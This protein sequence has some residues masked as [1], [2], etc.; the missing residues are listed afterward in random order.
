MVRSADTPYEAMSSRRGPTRSVRIL[1]S[2]LGAVLLVPPVASGGQAYQAAMQSLAFLQ[3]TA[4]PGGVHLRSL[5]EALARKDPTGAEKI[6][7]RFLE[8]VGD[9]PDARLAVGVAFAQH[10]YFSRAASHFAQA[11]RQ[12]P[13]NYTIDY[14]LGLALFRAGQHEQAAAVLKETTAYRDTAELRHLLADVYE[15][16][17]RYL[18]ALREYQNAVRLEPDNETYWFAL[19]YEMLKHRTYD[20][21]AATLEA[22]VQ[23]FP[24]SYRLRLALGITYF[25]RRQYDR[26]IGSFTKASDLQPALVGPYRMLAAACGNRSRWGE[27]VLTRLQRLMQ[28]KPE[29][30]WGPYLYGLAH[31]ESFEEA[32]ETDRVHS[33][34]DL[35]S[36]YRKSIALDPEFAEARYRLGR[37]YRKEGRLA[38]A[39]EQLKAAT[40]GRR[41]WPEPRYELARTYLQLGRKEAAER[42]FQR[43]RDL[44]KNEEEQRAEQ[45]Q[46]IQQF[47]L[48]LE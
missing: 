41:D 14:N 46:R 23:K 19:A 33:S 31:E 27:A 1:V 39:V 43:H 6:A 4:N 28:V 16:S 44:L 26:A 36:F 10:G 21:A 22:A 8:A 20:G 24:A 34:S 35:A 3:A 7:Q 18:E 48:L 11:R 15:D 42:E 45:L 47:I 12:A 13:H 30:P 25:A 29:T 40:R 9:Q 38:E 2:T 17:G 37:L 32:P 5:S